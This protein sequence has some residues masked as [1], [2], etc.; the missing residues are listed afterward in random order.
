MIAIDTAGVPSRPRAMKDLTKWIE[1]L[2]L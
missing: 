2:G 1:G